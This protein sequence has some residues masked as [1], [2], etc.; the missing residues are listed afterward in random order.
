MNEIITEKNYPVRFVWLFK[1]FTPFFLFVFVLFFAAIIV[2]LVSNFNSALFAMLVA[3]LYLVAGWPV[4]IIFLFFIIAV[5]RRANFHYEIGHNNMTFQQ[6][7]IFKKNRTLLYGS[8]Q[9]VMVSQKLFDRIFGLASVTIKVFS[10]NGTS[11]MGPD[12]YT[13]GRYRSEVLGFLGNRIHIPGLKQVDAEM[14]RSAVAER[15][16]RNPVSNSYSS[17]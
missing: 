9:G 10:D 11:L 13:R 14:I 3:I 4:L 17:L 2:G 7:I 16:K 15:I 8:V 1:I 12:G 5:L 6:G